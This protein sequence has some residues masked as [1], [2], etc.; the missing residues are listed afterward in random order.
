MLRTVNDMNSPVKQ[1][2]SLAALLLK[3][4]ILT[5][6][7]MDSVAIVNVAYQQF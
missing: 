6:L 2:L 5:Y 7:L 4:L 1:A 3:L